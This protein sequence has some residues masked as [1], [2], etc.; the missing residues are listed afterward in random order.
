MGSYAAVAAPQKTDGGVHMSWLRQHLTEELQRAG[1]RQ[2]A[3][4][5]CTPPRKPRG[6]AVHQSLVVP[7]ASRRH[8]VQRCCRHS[9]WQRQEHN[10]C[11]VAGVASAAMCPL[12][13]AQPDSCVLPWKRQEV[14]R[15]TASAPARPC[16]ARS[17][18]AST[19]PARTLCLKARVPWIGQAR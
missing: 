1:W 4:S 12:L 7:E 2:T 6:N 14:S 18:M 5:W 10:P 11:A 3:G 15:H 17:M 19:T 13:S 16:C 9:A 8:R